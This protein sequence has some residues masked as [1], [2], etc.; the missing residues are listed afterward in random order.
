MRPARRRTATLAAALLLLGSTAATAQARQLGRIDFANSGAATA[1]DDFIE[2]VL[3]LHSFE[4]ADAAES[5]RRAQAADPDFALAYW[6]EAMT[7]NHPL[8]REQDR[9]AALAVLARYEARGVAP[10]T[11]R[12]EAYLDALRTLYGEG[13]KAERDR[14][15]M[16]AMARMQE[17]WPEDLEARAFHAL[18]I[19]GS[20][21]GVRDFA[22]YMRAAATAQPVFDANPDHPGAVHYI[23]HS[24]DDPVHA[25]LGLPAAVAYSDIAPGAAHAQHMTSHIFVALGMWND[26]VAANVRARDVQDRANLA[27]GGRTNPCGHYTSWLHYG[28]LM[29]GRPEQARTSMDACLERMNDRPNPSEQNYFVNMRARQVLDL[30]DWEAAGRYLADLDAN[31]RARSAQAFVSAYAAARTGERD[32]AQ[33]LLGQMLDG[34]DDAR[35]RIQRLEIDAL[36]ALDAG[37]AERAVTLLEEAVALEETL[38]FEFGP[39][40]SLKPP[41]ELLG[42]VLV[43]VG[44]PAEA[45]EAFRRSLSFT[46]RRTRSLMGLAAAAA[47]AGMPTVA[48]DAKGELDEIWA[49]AEPGF[50]EPAGR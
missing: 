17:R 19:L 8:W 44:R 12:E 15:Y 35:V 23:I 7:Y 28:Y 26:V 14:A 34:D 45:V 21:D 13:S 30:E 39:P 5:F 42:E 50:V 47:G 48:A 29:Q 49:S 20:T 25:P 6:G 37:E 1:Q 24:F 10:P 27:E 22:T 3:L 36:L 33:A 38:P 31:P 32:R 46:P 2:G 41:H 18:A 9:E 16:D 43:E 4:F 40:A 11:E